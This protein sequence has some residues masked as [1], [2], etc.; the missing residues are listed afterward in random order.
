MITLS[1]IYANLACQVHSYLGT[2]CYFLSQN[3]RF[4]V[5]SPFPSASSTPLNCR[6]LSGC[7]RQRS[8]SFSL[9]CSILFQHLLRRMRTGRV[10][11]SLWPRSFVDDIQVV[12]QP[13]APGCWVSSSL[14]CFIAAFSIVFNFGECKLD[15]FLWATG[16]VTMLY[17]KHGK[18]LLDRLAVLY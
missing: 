10:Q 13:E 4:Q 9:L 3:E 2:R 16:K 15:G 17:F 18:L 1:A 5:A 11:A 7:F 12:E 14:F 6:W 8:V